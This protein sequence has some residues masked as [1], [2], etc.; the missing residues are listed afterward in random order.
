MT[1]DEFEEFLLSEDC[2]DNHDVSYIDY[3]GKQHYLQCENYWSYY[4]KISWVLTTQYTVK[5]EQYERKIGVIGNG[6][7]HVFYNKKNGPS[8]NTHTD[9]VDVIIVCTDG[10]K[11]LEVEGNAVVLKSGESITIKA[12]TPHRAL[13]YEKAL[14]ISYGVHDTETLNRICKDN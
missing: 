5:V 11:Y 7:A 6:T 8:F 2:Y 3:D 1:F 14:M 10:K 12:N 9:P 13:N 4:P